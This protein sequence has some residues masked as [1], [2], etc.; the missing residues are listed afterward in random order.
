M[1]ACSDGLSLK[2]AMKNRASTVA[3]NVA[4]LKEDADYPD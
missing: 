1:M 3:G 2:R 4:N